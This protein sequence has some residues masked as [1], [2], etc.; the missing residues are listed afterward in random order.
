[1]SSSSILVASLGFSLCSIVILTIN[2]S[3]PRKWYISPSVCV[4]LIS[5]NNVLEFSAYK[6]FVSLSRFIPQYF[7]LF[8]AVVNRIIS[9]ISTLD[10]ILL[11][12][13]KATDFSVLILYPAT[14]PNSLMSSSSF[15]AASLGFS[16]YTVMSSTNSDIFTS[17]PVWIHFISFSSLVS[18]SRNR[19]RVSRIAGR[20][21]TIWATREALV[22]LPKL[23]WIKVAREESSSCSWS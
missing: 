18:M 9:W 6:S 22:G 16:I 2:S 11:V 15:V 17:L 23:H 21:F 5:F 19:T 12:H 13:T 4:I 14:L 8:N 20:R 3:N 10:L 1:M 7:I